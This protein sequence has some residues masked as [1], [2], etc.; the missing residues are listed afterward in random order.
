MNEEREPLDDRELMMRAK[1]EDTESFAELVR[2]HQRALLNHFLRC[3]AGSDAEDLV[4]QTFVRVFRYRDRYRPTAKFTTFLFLV[5]RQVWIDELRKRRNVFRLQEAWKEEHG[6]DEMDTSRGPS[7]AADAVDLA[8][9]LARLGDGARAVVDLGV[10]Q[11]LAYPEIARI[12]GIPVGT[13]KSRMFNALRALREFMHAK[14][15]T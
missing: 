13:V 6:D 14:D 4:Q 10:M 5:A 7:A 15:K 8:E 1:G 3:G 2:R 11:G 12:L 9:A